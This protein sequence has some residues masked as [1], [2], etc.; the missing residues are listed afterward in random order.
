M[1]ANRNLN[2]DGWG[3]CNAPVYDPP[4]CT[5]YSD[6]EVREGFDIEYIRM[7]LALS[8]STPLPIVLQVV[9]AAMRMK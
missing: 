9:P 3:M 5:G 4:H 2:Y 1:F 8:Q 7:G 6:E